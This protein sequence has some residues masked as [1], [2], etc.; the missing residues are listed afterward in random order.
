MER[1]NPKTMNTCDVLRADALEIFHAALRAAD[2]RVAIWRVLTR[3]GNV[4]LLNGQPFADLTRG[5]VRVIGMGKAG[6]P[7]AQ[8]VEEIVGDKIDAGAVT[9]K[10][11]H[12]AP[13]RKIK[14]NE[15]GH[16]LP[17]PNGVRATHEIVDLVRNLSADDLVICVVSGG[18]S[19]LMEWLVEGVTLDDLRALTSELLRCG[20]TIQEINALRKHLSRVKGGQLAR[21]AQ[22][23]RMLTLILS[24]V[25]GS[26]LDVIA[27]GP[28]AP[29][30]ST[31]ADCLR[32]VDTYALREKIPANILTHLERGTRGEIPE[33][34]KAEDALFARVT[35]VIVADNQI[36]CA[37]AADEA[38][39][40]GYA[41]NV[42]GTQLQGNARALALD[43]AQRGLRARPDTCIL[44]GGEPTVVVRGNGKGGRAQE[45][46]LAAAREIDGAKNIVLLSAGTDGT[47]GPTDAAGALADHET[48]ARARALGLDADAFLENNDAYPF[49]RALND[50]VMT[51]P[52]NTNV[53][54]LMIVLRG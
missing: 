47:D 10:Y 42:I 46:V 44:G 5:R 48:M 24:D 25:L 30:S 28:T 4:L 15:A 33:T 32:I 12:V 37:A 35:N 41:V 27:S 36:A 13:T 40:R 39:R 38:T 52:T 34:P 22:P 19:A 43:F 6:A 7:M 14:I 11:K 49:F 3:D 17:D 20:A 18:G 29:D 31:F 21:L 2:P 51:G 54:D 16:P 1:F 9:V 50:L 26:P 8:A 45:L 23:A 53:N